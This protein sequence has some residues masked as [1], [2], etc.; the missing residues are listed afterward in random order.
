[1]KAQ[2]I[3]FY[4]DYYNSDLSLADYAKSKNVTEK[5]CSIICE[6]GKSLIAIQE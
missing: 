3:I 2:I 6:A 1:M 4:L 5:E